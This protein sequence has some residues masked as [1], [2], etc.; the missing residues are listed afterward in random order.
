MDPLTMNLM[1][2]VAGSGGSES[3]FAYEHSSVFENYGN[4]GKVDDDGN[5][6]IIH[7]V[8][9]PYVG[10]IYFLAK[11]NSDGEYQWDK[12]STR[13]T[14]PMGL[15]TDSSGN[16][17]YM[18]TGNQSD[19]TSERSFYVYKFNASGTLQF[20]TEL[21]PGTTSDLMGSSITFNGTSMDSSGNIYLAGREVFSTSS[22]KFFAKWNSSG[23]LQSQER[24]GAP[25]GTNANYGTVV[26]A[27]NTTYPIFAGI[28]EPGSATD[29]YP[30]IM[31]SGA[32]GGNARYISELP[33]VSGGL[34]TTGAFSKAVEVDS[35]GNIYWL[36]KGNNQT[37]KQGCYL[38]KM[39]SSF[40]ISWQRQ[41]SNNQNLSFGTDL[42]LDSNGNVYVVGQKYVTSP[43]THYKAFFIKFNS[44]GTVQFKR[45]FTYAVTAKSYRATGLDIKGNAA[46]IWTGAEPFLKVPLDGSLT[47]TYNTDY[48]YE[49]ES[50]FTISTS[51][52]TLTSAT[53]GRSSTSYTSQTP[54]TDGIIELSTD[55]D[56]LTLISLE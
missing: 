49:A 36:L 40:N 29:Y 46:Y 38:I 22:Y 6:Y 44:S 32:T 55:P 45:Q 15:E 28:D 53:V 12:R 3:Y 20:V 54:S 13:M 23:T 9:Q 51:S 19:D 10:Q 21:A 18:G 26:Q 50:D 52:L 39:D 30:Y 7:D 16:V 48:L 47:G 8:F 17:Y 25:D 27:K 14:Y 37:G 31:L 33:Y 56:D 2:Q 42:K 41:I 4:R 24:F 11:Y 43:L 34:S 35:S 1:R 5:L